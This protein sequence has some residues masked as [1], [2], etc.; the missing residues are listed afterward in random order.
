[1]LAFLIY[2][3][4]PGLPLNPHSHIYS[5]TE[6]ECTGHVLF[7]LS[8]FS[9]LCLHCIC[10]GVHRKT[11]KCTLSARFAGTGRVASSSL[12]LL[13]RRIAGNR[14]DHS[15]NSSPIANRHTVDLPRTALARSLRFVRCFLPL[16]VNPVSVVQILLSV[17]HSEE[18]F[19]FALS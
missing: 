15:K 9:P 19:F 1:M 18:E 11:R 8:I 16:F 7:K 4:T 2:T 17:A 3:R 5:R 10:T 14:A 6:I 12:S 13:P